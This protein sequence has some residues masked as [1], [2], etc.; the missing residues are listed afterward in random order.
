MGPELVLSAWESYR[1]HRQNH[2]G[3]KRVEIKGQAAVSSLFQASDNAVR[4]KVIKQTITWRLFL[5]E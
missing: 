2:I 1:K 3:N 5:L 4:E